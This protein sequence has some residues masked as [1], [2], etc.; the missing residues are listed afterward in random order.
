MTK[1]NQECQETKGELLE[2]VIKLCDTFQERGI[3]VSSIEEI[4]E[5]PMPET[6]QAFN[7]VEALKEQ[8]RAIQEKLDVC[9]FV[10]KPSDEVIEII[11]E[12]YS[13]ENL[14]LAAKKVEWLKHTGKKLQASDLEG[15]IR[16]AAKKHHKVRK[17]T[18]D[19]AFKKEKPWKN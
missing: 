13:I 3:S 9:E 19:I 2:A 17:E 12:S 5:A 14:E 11:T 15:N 16:E 10:E 1:P 7:K 18:L 6:Q 8:A 4:L